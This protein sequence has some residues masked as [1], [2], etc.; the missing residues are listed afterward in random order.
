MFILLIFLSK[1]QLLMEFIFSSV[2]LF[3]VS[4]ISALCYYCLFSSSLGFSYVWSAN[5]KAGGEWVHGLHF[6]I[7]LSGGCQRLAEF[8]HWRVQFLLCVSSGNYSHSLFF[9]VC[10]R[11]IMIP[12]A[13]RAMLDTKHLIVI[14]WFPL[15]LSVSSLT[16]PN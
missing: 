13:P 3:S 7:F 12:L 1:C 11:V 14:C 9:Q 10:L 16:V 15:I 2:F 5:Q 6:S 8:V 4:F